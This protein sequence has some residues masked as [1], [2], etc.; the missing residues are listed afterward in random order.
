MVA[1]REDG[2][3]HDGARAVG[4]FAGQRPAVDRRPDEL[5]VEAAEAR[6]RAQLTAQSLEGAHDGFLRKGDGI[7]LGDRGM[8]D[9]RGVAGLL[10]GP[11]GAVLGEDDQ[12][13]APGAR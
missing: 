10:L 8:V 3:A 5:H 12:R 1:H 4:D 7:Q 13:P 6:Q 9:D 11:S 2:G